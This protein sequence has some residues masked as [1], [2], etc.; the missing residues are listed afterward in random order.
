MLS[1]V[2]TILISVKHYQERHMIA[3]P[4]VDVLQKANIIFYSAEEA[5]SHINSIWDNIFLWWDSENVKLARNLFKNTALSF[6]KNWYKEWKDF[7]KIL[8]A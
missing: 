1:D 8:K 2:P 6:N 5:A 4:L 3:Y 7:I